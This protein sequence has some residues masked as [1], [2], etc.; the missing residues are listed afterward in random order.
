MLG[1]TPIIDTERLIKKLNQRFL[2]RRWE[3][4]G[5]L[6]TKTAKIDAM[7]RGQRYR[8]FLKKIDKPNQR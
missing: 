4:G 5:H 8:S 2:T 1:K 7:K 3:R 6:E